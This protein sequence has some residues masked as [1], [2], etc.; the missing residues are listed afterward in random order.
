MDPVTYDP[1]DGCGQMMA[2]FER[3]ASEM[4][5]GTG[6]AGCMAGLDKIAMDA[7][8]GPTPRE[9]LE[10]AAAGRWDFR[11]VDADPRVA[12]PAVT[13]LTDYALQRRERVAA[14]MKRHPSYLAQQ[15]RLAQTD[16]ETR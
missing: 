14:D 16:E 11:I 12:E 3:T 15:A 5:T 10:Q 4:T 2:D 13:S 6:H 1:C 8:Y 7:L 9:H